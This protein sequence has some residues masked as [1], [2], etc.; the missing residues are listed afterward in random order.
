NRTVLDLPSLGLEKGL[1]YSLQ[2]PNGSGKTTLLEILS[3]LAPPTSGEIMYEGRKVAPGRNNLTALRREIVMVPQNPILF[4]TTV[5]KNVALGLKLRGISREERE[6][7]VDECLDLVGMRDFLNAP[8]HKLSGG[9]TQRIA[10]ARAL[11]CSPK[12]IF[13]DEPTSNVDTTSQKA[14]ERI[15]RDINARK[16]ISLVFT[17]H[18]PGQASRLSHRV[19]SLF[20]GRLVNSAFGNIFKGHISMDG[21]GREICLLEDR[22]R[23]VV[24]AH[25]SGDVTLSLNPTK[26]KILGQGDPKPLQNCMR[27]VIVRLADE[28]NQTLLTLDIGVPLN[29]LFS[30]DSTSCPPLSLRREVEVYCPPEAI[31]VL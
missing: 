1:I 9:E 12:V 11:A 31:Q 25:R 5:W 26:I 22:V 13:F 7:A 2:G 30:T 20:E 17:S 19:I 4:S 28:G 14:I 15:M 24:E 6:R 8:A 10:I 16:D 21:R 23:L 27:G 18:D 29:I 3:F